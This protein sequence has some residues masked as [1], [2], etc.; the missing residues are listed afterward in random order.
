MSDE[1]SGGTGLRRTEVVILCLV[2]GLLLLV[3]WN[4]L[5]TKNAR[6][7]PDLHCITQLKIIDGAAQQW[8]LEYGKRTND[9]YSLSDRQ[10][11]AFLKGSVL[12]ACPK[13]GRYTAGTN[14]A[15]VP[16]CNIPGHTL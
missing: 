1:T 3:G 2:A 4:V 12:P 15:D 11:L 16:K 13:G 10:V 9:T 8:A 6:H 7:R 14:I 5:S